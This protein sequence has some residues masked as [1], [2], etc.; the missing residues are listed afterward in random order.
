M[1]AADIENRA[2]LTPKL[3]IVSIDPNCMEYDDWDDNDDDDDGG[4][5]CSTTP[6][7]SSSSGFKSHEN[8]SEDLFDEDN[9]RRPHNIPSSKDLSIA[10]DHSYE[11]NTGSE[12]IFTDNSKEFQ[13]NCDQFDA[14]ANV[15]NWLD[16]TSAM[17]L[18]PK[19]IKIKRQSDFPIEVL[20]HKRIELGGPINKT[21]S[22]RIDSENAVAHKRNQLHD[23]RNAENLVHHPLTNAEPTPKQLDK[24]TEKSCGPVNNILFEKNQIETINRPNNVQPV[25]VKKKLNL[26]EYLKRRPD[27]KRHSSKVNEMKTEPNDWTANQNDAKQDKEYI[28]KSI[29][30]LYE[31]IIV[32]S[33]GSNTDVT[34]PFNENLSGDVQSIKLIS[35]IT[36]T[37]TKVKN[38]S[39]SLIASIRDVIIK[40]SSNLNCNGNNV[41][42]S[43]NSE[44]VNETE[45]GEDKTI[46]HLKK[47]RIRNKC[48]SVGVQ[49][50]CDIRFPVLERPKIAVYAKSLSRSPSTSSRSSYSSYSSDN[51][52]RKSSNDTRRSISRSNYSS[53]SNLGFEKSYK[54]SRQENDERCTVYVGR[55]ETTTSKEDLKKKFEKYGPIK[56]ISTHQKKNGMKFG[57]VTFKSAKDAYNTID[58]SAADSSIST[59]D[60]SFG[61][62]RAFCK[63]SYLDL[64]NT[65][66]Y[67]QGYVLPTVQ[68]NDSFEDLLRKVKLEIESSQKHIK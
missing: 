12:S 29:Q 25:Q 58:G 32:V 14:Y 36:D 40:K 21:E 8:D 2:F 3:E 54:R 61:G 46:M 60:I 10:S 11:K 18:F 47:D 4:S 44:V 68:Q 42:D 23:K 28:A 15:V 56:E 39:N 59:Y 53:W 9:L 27:L 62:R 63:E 48:A 30:D 55:I 13:T 50:D 26:E 67:Q 35:E 22:Q 45:H 37:I 49:T 34:I 5:S 64:D 31:E 19:P 41:P 52:K 6:S 24:V 7:I 66:V 33:I 43:T 57:F 20:D 17:P 65:N 51:R 38:D 1:I 16:S